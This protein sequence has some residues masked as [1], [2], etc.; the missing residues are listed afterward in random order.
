MNNITEQ[1]KVTWIIGNTVLNGLGHENYRLTEDSSLPEYN[2]W[3]EAMEWAK[4]KDYFPNM[5]E[6]EVLDILRKYDDWN[7]FE[8]NCIKTGYKI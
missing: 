8:K 7:E 3:K 2:Y 6:K 5:S 1:E 4:S